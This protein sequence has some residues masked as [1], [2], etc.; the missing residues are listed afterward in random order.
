[1]AHAS[2]E[3]LAHL[4]PPY[5]KTFTGQ[6]DSAVAT[7]NDASLGYDRFSVLDTSVKD[8]HTLCTQ[9]FDTVGHETFM[10]RKCS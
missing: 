1:M 10:R 2:A 5:A 3:C 4:W 8:D 6:P 9:S 7:S